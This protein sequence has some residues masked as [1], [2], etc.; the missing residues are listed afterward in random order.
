MSVP[1]GETRRAGLTL[2]E[3]MIVILIL[4]IAARI[5]VLVHRELGVR[6]QAAAVMSDLDAVRAAAFSYHAETDEW[7]PDVEPGVLPPELAPYLGPGFDFDRDAYR[8]DWD[9]WALPD[10]TPRQPEPRVV[11]GV[12]VTAGDAAFG[13]ALLER[14]E[15][16]VPRIELAGRYTFI[17]AVR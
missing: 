7:P 14:V 8:L 11:L 13:R 5:A 12:S 10:G 4:G 9:H 17:I 2:V 16:D 1:P 3:L 15:E 6:S